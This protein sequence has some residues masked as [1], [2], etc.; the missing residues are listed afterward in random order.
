MKHIIRS[1]VSAGALLALLNFGLPSARA[2]QT[3]VKEF[4]QPLHTTLH[5]DEVGCLNH[6]G[7]Q[8]TVTGVA[9]IGGLQ[10]QLILEN[11]VKG[12]HETEITLVTNLVL[13]PFGT[14]IVIPKQPVLG[15]VGGNPFISL[16]FFNKDGDIG[17]EIF[18]GRCVQGLSLD[19]DFIED[20]IARLLISVLGCENHPG[21]FITVGGDLKVAGLSARII[22]RNN[23]K[24]THTAETDSDIT[25]IGD[26]AVVTIPKQPVLG[27]VGSNPLIF[28]RLLQ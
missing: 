4:N 10:V 11:N 12:T 20:S 1:A 9:L 8:I 6:P 2:D 25:I 22:F 26:G 27:G 24:G 23:V 3:V 7:P 21:P 17:D 18:L 15:G 16:Q 5:I 13:V 14:P 19:N 28:V